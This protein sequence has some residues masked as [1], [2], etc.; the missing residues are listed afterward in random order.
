MIRAIRERGPEAMGLLLIGGARLILAF[1][2]VVMLHLFGS[3]VFGF[4]L[5]SVP[6]AAVSLL[7]VSLSFLA[8]LGHEWGGADEHEAP[9]QDEALE[10]HRRSTAGHDHRHA[11]RSLLRF[12]W[13]R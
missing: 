4:S 11:K 3:A 9:T 12:R 10:A 13:S 5:V 7:S 6:F 8:T 2:V 1:L